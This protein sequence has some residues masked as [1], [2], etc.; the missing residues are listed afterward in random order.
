MSD[1]RCSQVQFRIREDTHTSWPT[2]MFSVS[3]KETGVF[4]KQ[5][6]F[7]GKLLPVSGAE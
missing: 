4:L 7:D 1:E 6:I 5:Y 3:F 2:F